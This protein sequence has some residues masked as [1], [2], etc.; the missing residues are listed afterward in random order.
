[1]YVYDEHMHMHY[2]AGAFLETIPFHMM[3]IA[4][5]VRWWNQ[6]NMFEASPCRK[7]SKHTRTQPITL[8]IER[9]F[10]NILGK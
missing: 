10:K 2:H 8:N 7:Q 9:A 5:V 3:Y 1:M 6:R 4:I